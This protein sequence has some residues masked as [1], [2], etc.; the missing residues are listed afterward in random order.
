MYGVVNRML[1]LFAKFFQQVTYLF[2]ETYDI[3]NDSENEEQKSKLR[4]ELHAR[5]LRGS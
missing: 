1:I 3:E 2:R 5:G 4:T